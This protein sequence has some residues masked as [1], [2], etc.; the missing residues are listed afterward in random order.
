MDKSSDDHEKQPETA[1]QVQRPAAQRQRPDAV[2][3]LPD[4]SGG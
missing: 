2:I 3:H 4:L 1:D